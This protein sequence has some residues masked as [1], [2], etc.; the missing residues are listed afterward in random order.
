MKKFKVIGDWTQHLPND[1][2]QKA[3]DAQEYLKAE[4][5]WFEEHRQELYQ[6]HPD[7]WAVVHEGRLIGV[8][9]SF[10]EAFEK[11]SDIVQSDRILVKQI[12]LEDPI[13]TAPAYT[14]G[15]ICAANTGGLS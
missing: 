15:I 8:Y 2:R 13:F 10:P 7:K 4:L 6:A 5:A 11:G 9:D 3:M 14:L 12:L 1:L